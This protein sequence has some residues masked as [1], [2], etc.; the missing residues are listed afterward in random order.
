MDGQRCTTSG[1]ATT[2]AQASYAYDSVG[3]R[4]DLGA[5]LIAG[6]R[7]TA[8]NGYALTYDSAG[9]LFHKSKTGFDQYLYWNSLGRL[10]SAK[11]NG[12]LVKYGYDPQGRRVRRATST[13]TL[14]FIHD[15]AQVI[16]EVDSATGTR[17]KVYTYYPGADR[18]HSVIQAG[19]TYYYIQELQGS[20]SILGLI[21]TAG[22]IKNRYGYAP[23]GALEDSSELV[24]N[25]M[26][27]TAREWDSATMLYY[28]RARYY[29]PVLGRFI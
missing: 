10:D 17:Q 11:T 24:A 23:W 5:T 13:Q 19:K 22:T 29:D 14:Y 18:P 20:G 3:N 9:R 25:P 15:G 16:A 8:F 12:A 1:G 2:L 27:F 21:D 6:N 26:R 7:L 4:T 28:Y